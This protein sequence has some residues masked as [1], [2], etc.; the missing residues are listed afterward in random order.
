MSYSSPIKVE[1]P[2]T[3]YV[4]DD[5][6]LRSHEKKEKC[7]KGCTLCRKGTMTRALTRTTV[8]FTINKNT[9]VREQ[10]KYSCGSPSSALFSVE[11]LMDDRHA[12]FVIF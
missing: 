8:A 5:F 4:Q 10:I 11:K 6:R 3:Q 7:K 2:N 9:L 1:R 12:A